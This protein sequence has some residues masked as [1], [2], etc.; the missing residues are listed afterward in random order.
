M[1]TPKTSARL[2]AICHFRR[3]H[4][5]NDLTF[6]DHDGTDFGTKAANRQSIRWAIR[7]SHLQCRFV[8]KLALNNSLGCRLRHSA[9]RC[10]LDGL[11][12]DPSARSLELHSA[13][14]F[15]HL[16]PRRW[17]D[18]VQHA[19]AISVVVNTAG[20]L[21][22]AMFLSHPVSWHDVDILIDDVRQ[23]LGPVVFRCFKDWL[24]PKHPQQCHVS[25]LG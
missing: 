23:D 1:L 6:W 15:L 5:F 21:A 17:I 16:R 18:P 20:Y 3:S 11:N 12:P 25:G 4:V 13:S 14:I 7:L 9:Q 2:D 8:Y 22:I 10:D 19:P 24:R